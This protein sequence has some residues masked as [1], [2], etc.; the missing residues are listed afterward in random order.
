MKRGWL[1]AL[2]TIILAGGIVSTSYA[3]VKLGGELRVRGV[4]V[5]NKEGAATYTSGGFFEQRT[6]INVDASVDENAKVFVQVQDSRKWG[7]E[8]ST[9]DTGLSTTC[10]IPDTG[11]TCTDTKGVDLSQGYVEIGKLF[12]Q[13]LSV[14][15]G[16]QAMA[17]GEHRL[18]GALEWSNNARRFDALKFTYKHDAVDVDVFTAKLSETGGV[19]GDDSNLNGLYASLKV[20]PKNAVDVYLLNKTIGASDTN[21]H[22]IGA[23]VKGAVAEVNVDYNAEVAIQTGDVTEDVKQQ[24][25]AFAVRAGYT[26]PDVM[27][28]R[29]G[30]EY[31]NASGDDDGTDDTVKTFD[32]L[33]PTGHYLWGFTDDI[34]WQNVNA[35]S[36]NASLKP[37]DNLTVALEYWIYKA[38]EE[39][40]DGNDD[41]GTEINIKANH[42]LS[43][44]IAC[45]AA[46][47]MRANGDYGAGTASYGGFGSIPDDESSTF[48]YFMINVKFM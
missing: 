2:A 30:V 33:Y 19:F 22:T 25:S 47:V 17:Y 26:L 15:L 45:E 29:V 28:L 24:A 5:D 42:D 4:T 11:G 27:G 12:G 1:I 31:D 46:Y 43:K 39:D 38:N 37:M 23:R 20:V 8:A 21:F 3:E 13:P 32:E 35:I 40:T 18:I 44:N 16:R 34:K 6:R 9:I 14:R 7:S 48:G 10:T 36:V 41:R